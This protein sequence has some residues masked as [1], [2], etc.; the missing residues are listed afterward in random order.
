MLKNT[1]YAYGWVSIFLHWSMAILMLGLFALGLYMTDLDYYD[2]WYQQAPHIHESVGII[3]FALLL[4]RITWR[5]TNPQPKLT[6][7]HW[8][9]S[10]ALITHRLH[11]IL[12]ISL[13]FTG[14]LIPTAKGVGITVFDWFTL[15]SINNVFG[16]YEYKTDLI[17]QIHWGS[18]WA[19]IVLVGLHSAAALK[20]HFINH[21]NTLFRMFGIHHPS[22]HN[23]RRNL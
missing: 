23:S 21:D 11:Y 16:I 14:Y 7:S 10:A 15:P 8:E 4:W 12:M 5:L 20:H 9:N 18:A 22:S 6:G 3:V 13:V 19:M 1:L 17:G 2:K